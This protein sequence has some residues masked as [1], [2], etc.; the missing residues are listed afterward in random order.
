VRLLSN[1]TLFQYPDEVQ[2]PE[3]SSWD[4]YSTEDDKTK[5]DEKDFLVVG[6]YGPDDPEVRCLF[7]ALVAT[8]PHTRFRILITGQAAGNCWSHSKCAS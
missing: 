6:W 7:I 1:D 2:T 3:I 4:Q 8:K 5:K